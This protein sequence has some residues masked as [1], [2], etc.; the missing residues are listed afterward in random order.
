M[1]TWT[2]LN[3][4][5]TD[6]PTAQEVDTK[7]IQFSKKRL[8]I[9]KNNAEL[10]LYSSPYSF[11]WSPPARK[12]SCKRAEKK[13][14]DHVTRARNLIR[15]IVECNV[16]DEKPKFVTYTFGKEIL[17]LKDANVY[18]S[19]F[20]KR[21]NRK[22]GRLKYLAVPEFQPISG[23]VHYHVI[24]FNMPFLPK[25][26]TRL[27]DLWGNGFV[28]VIAI[29]KIQRVSLYVSKYIQKGLSDPRSRGMKSFFC[30]RGIL[31]PIEYRNES[32]IDKKLASLIL[33]FEAQV[34]Y[35]SRL[36][37]ITYKKY[38]VQN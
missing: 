10:F 16:G 1:P 35:P 12:P 3:T 15:R 5:L 36:G 29:K 28:K 26:K 27:A 22:Y 4:H 20:V 18:W 24:Y 13:R 6:I 38:H 14:D 8:I 19:E 34:I 2:R 7:R 11:N 31:R 37:D 9:S 32:R 33:K 30:S 23:R 21:M 17:R 25:I